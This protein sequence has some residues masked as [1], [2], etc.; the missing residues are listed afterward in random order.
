MNKSLLPLELDK[1]ECNE[2]RVK[3]YHFPDEV[4]MTKGEVVTNL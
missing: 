2:D 4:F 3:F 1:L